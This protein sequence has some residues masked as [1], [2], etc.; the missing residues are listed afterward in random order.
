MFCRANT[1]GCDSAAGAL[2]LISI[3]SNSTE[4]LEFWRRIDVKAATIPQF[5]NRDP[6]TPVS[7]SVSVSIIK[8]SFHK[9]LNAYLRVTITYL[10]TLNWGPTHCKRSATFHNINLRTPSYV[11]IVYR[12]SA[13]QGR[14]QIYDLGYL[15]RRHFDTETSKSEPRTTYSR[16]RYRWNRW[17]FTTHYRPAVHTRRW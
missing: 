3:H 2:Q 8:T 16:Y 6:G 7:V 17:S 9:N 14:A 10:N 11:T 15:V 1:R 13:I 12:R 4:A 5:W